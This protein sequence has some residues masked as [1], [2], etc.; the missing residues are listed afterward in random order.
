MSSISTPDQRVYPSLA[1]I[2]GGLAGIAA[3]ESALQNGFRVTLFE[4]SRVLGGR[5]AS[6]FDPNTEQWIDNGQHVT[7]GC[8]TELLDLNQ[9]LGLT[10]FFEQKKTIPFAQIGGQ[11]GT[12]ASVTWLPNHWQ[13]LPA[14]LTFPFLSLKE[15]FTTGLLL[16]ELGTQKNVKVH[17]NANAKVEVKVPESGTFAQ[18]LNDK[19]VSANAIEKFWAPLIFSTLSESID[20]VSFNAVQQI[21]RDS[22]LA[23]HR[24]MTFYIPTVPLRTIY[25]E[26][27]AEQ[28]RN[29]GIELNFLKRVK[30]L[31][32]EFQA[33]PDFLQS[34]N[35]EHHTRPKIHALELSDGS[36]QSFDYYLLAVP[37]LQFQEIMIDSDLELYT[38][39]LALERFEP[40]SITTIHL[41]FN[42]RILPAELSHSAL[43]GGPGQFLFCPGKDEKNNHEKDNHE[44]NNKGIYHNVVISASHRLLVE[45]EFTSRGSFGLVERVVQQLQNTFVRSFQKETTQLLFHRVTTH[46]EAVFSPNPAVYLERPES[47]TPFSN[48]VLAGDWTQTKL[49]ATLESAVRSGRYA[50]QTLKTLETL[51]RTKE[52]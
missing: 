39:Q 15:R 36:R 32:W 44:K 24:A 13:F 46:F 28:L 5:A 19:K 50:V 34:D 11:R 2:G 48:L 52:N 41:W 10:G 40:G 27:T 37:L 42:H 9:Q 7:L 3:A 21:V 12:I 4:R 33:E 23:G 16:R 35:T 14:F 29:R 51:H 22:F 38:E 31:C 1:V 20:Y 17:V 43:L 49:P 45:H 6:L 18:W 30:R 26:A 25:H 8:C 47:A